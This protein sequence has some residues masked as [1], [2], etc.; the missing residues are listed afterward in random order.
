[1]RLLAIDV[2]SS[3]CKVAAFSATGEMVAIRSSAYAPHFPRPGFAELDSEIFFN[4]ATLL[5]REVSG[6]AGGRIDAVCFSSHG[7]TLIPT[8]AD[9]RALCP[10]ILNIDSRARS[11]AEWCEQKIGRERLFSLTGH[12]S[13]SMYPIPKLIWLSRNAPE[14]FSSAARFLSVTDY[15]LHRL[16]LEPLVD[17]SHA[18]RF[19]AFD[20][21]AGRWSQEVL[22]AARI[23][24]GKL[25]TPVQAG[26][27]ANKLSNA[28]AAMLGVAEGTAVVVGGHDQVVGAVGLG[29]VGAGR[30]AGSLGTY[31][32]ILVA[33]DEPQLNHAALEGRLCSYPHAVPGKFVTIAFFPAGITLE[34]IDQFLYQRK[35]GEDRE[36][37]W[38]ALEA[39]APEGP[40][41]LLV[42]PHLVG[43]CNPDFDSRA[44]AA[45]VGLTPGVTPSHLY[46]GA[47]EG[48]ACELA[49]ITEYLEAAGCCFSDSN[50]SGG[51]T[52]S[53]LGVRLRA[54]FTGKKLHIMNCQ[55]SVCLGGA[56]LAAVA[57]GIYPDLKSAARAMVRE[58]ECV[59]PNHELGQEY[60]PQV[61]NYRGLRSFL[62]GKPL[63]TLHSGEQ[64]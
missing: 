1:M 38:R 20:V 60:S 19:M 30:A 31:E 50:V 62:V 45:I 11:E 44:T 4:S 53:P 43:T 47:L 27:I 42:T 49:L 40:T 56:M 52:R 58:K 29:V 32:C 5:A 55:E 13:H 7:E 14:T 63:R 34:W 51:G 3:R 36:E 10:A 25:P 15:L 12:T 24:E 59:L 33:S 37:H 26:T 57:I 6:L 9:G 61:A 2:G 22:A 64:V 39:G 54:A 28:S 48:I 17:Y 18:S 8:G 21:K 35:N 41:N 23:P 16:G 46:K